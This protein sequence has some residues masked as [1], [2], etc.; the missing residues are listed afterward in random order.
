MKYIVYGLLALLL[1]NG[2]ASVKT[3]DTPNEGH[4]AL[5]TDDRNNDKY[6]RVYLEYRPYEKIVERTKEIAELQEW[7]DDKLRREEKRIP[8]GGVLVVNITRMVMDEAN[9]KYF[10]TFGEMDGIEIFSVT[11]RASLA[12]R[13][14]SPGDVWW[15]SLE[16]KIRQRV[17]GPFK[18]YVTD[19]HN[20]YQYEYT[21]TP[22]FAIP[23]PE[24]EEVKEEKAA[25][26]EGGEVKEQQEEKKE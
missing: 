17:T 23:K 13:L 12:S 14:T 10:D 2:C 7:P 16:A 25:D 4:G 19:R 3:V 20:D 22:E 21:V 18:V 1:I 24:G 15:N 6:G 9:T 26:K 11:G 5:I 8:Y